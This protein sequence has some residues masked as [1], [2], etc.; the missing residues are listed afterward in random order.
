MVATTVLLAGG[1]ALSPVAV[2]NPGAAA[3]SAAAIRNTVWLT[4]RRVAL[5]V[6]SPAMGTQIQ[7]QL[8]LARDWNSKPDSRFP[9]LML[10]DGMAAS[11]DQSGWTKE[12]GAE[13]FYADKNVT[14]VLPV[15][16]AGSYYTDW[17]QPA[18]GQTYR[19]ETF[20]TKELP[21]LLERDWRATDVRGVAGV[22]MGGAA[23]MMLAART[24]GFARFAGS[25]SG[26]LNTTS[27]GMPQAIRRALQDVAGY[28]SD[29]MW[30]PST[31]GEWAAH[32]PY[33]LAERLKGVSLYVSS[34]SGLAGAIGL[35]AG[36]PGV[37]TD[38]QSS[39]LEVLSRFSS[40]E[41]VAKLN[42][43]GIS[44]QVNYRPSGTHSWPY[45]DFEMRQSWAQTE[46]ALGVE[47]GTAG[48]TATGVIAT[49]AQ[50]KSWL[51][52][53]LTPEYPVSGGMAR[54][55]RGGRVVWSPATGAYALG[56]MIGGA[57][58]GAAGPAG[59]LG[60][61]ITDEMP[62]PGGAQQNFQHGSIVFHDGKTE[63]RLG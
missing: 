50:S 22:S 53:C 35:P 33:S 14:V 10:L 6:D 52:D 32:D 58:A 45:W 49:V 1:S 37:S 3:P 51:G 42:K 31:D 55:F 26:V 15:G 63:I 13:G 40:R 30:G 56:G 18:N 29:A 41:F 59:A 2:A 5:W 48:C 11:E 25:F 4:G 27:F 61:P 7:V 57:Y 38:W 39:A 16:G 62:V 28:D 46:S 60:F 44:A 36:V 23:A 24:P 8:L 12:T 54:D 9:V 43:L 21:P 17:K 47:S 20:L 19:W 34:G